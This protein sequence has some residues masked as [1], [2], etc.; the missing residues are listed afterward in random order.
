MSKSSP[1]ND[2]NIA[3]LE[4]LTEA[5]IDMTTKLDKISPNYGA[6]GQLEQTLRSLAKSVNDG[7]MTTKQ[8]LKEAASTQKNIRSVEYG[9]EDTARYNKTVSMFIKLLEEKIGDSKID[10]VLIDKITTAFENLDVSAILESEK[11]GQ[12]GGKGAPLKNVMDNEKLNKVNE[13]LAKRIGASLDETTDKL[14]NFF[15]EQEDRK[16][17]K[18]KRFADDLIEG[19]EKSKWVGG[20]M[21]DTF[22]LIGLLGA[23]WMRQF[24][25]L[26]RILG[27][28]FYV[29]MET[30]GPLLV[31]LLLQGM[32]KLLTGLPGLIGKF[33]WGA[34]AGVAAGTVGAMWAFGEARDSERKG[35][36]GN[37]EAFR[38]GGIGMA[39]GA[40]GIGLASL[41]SMGAGAA[42][43]T[44]LGSALA[45]IAGIL[46]PIGWT[47]LGIGAAV[48][49]IAWAW[50]HHSDTIKKWA[51][52]FVE[53]CDKVIDF[54][55]MFNPIF[56]AI[57]WIR[58]NWPWGGDSKGGHSGLGSIGGNNANKGTGIAD[59]I[60]DNKKG[61]YVTYGKMKVSKRDGSI[62]NLHELTQDEAS[63]AL[64]MYE[65]AD[66]TSFN[67]L[68]EWLEGDKASL[69]SHSTDAVKKVGGKKVAAL[70]HKGASKEIDD[71]RAILGMNIVQTSGKLTGSNIFHGVGGWKSHNNQYGLGFDLAGDSSWTAK[72]Y[73]RN[74][75]KVRSYY[76]KLG[77][78]VVLERP[79]QGK[80]TGFH[81]DIKPKK[82]WR[83]EGA[84][85]NFADYEQAQ[86]EAEAAKASDAVSR[87]RVAKEILKEVDPQ[88]L[89]DINSS[90]P[91]VDDKEKT[92]EAIA[93]KYE[94][95]LAPHNIYHDSNL[96]GNNYFVEDSSGNRTYLNLAP[97]NINFQLQ[98]LQQRGGN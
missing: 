72:D 56:K 49:G 57:Q 19:L 32:G 17:K 97:G 65:K 30:A 29:A 83:P 13:D 52:K 31:R 1:N 15:Q 89:K 75:E 63:K 96:K 79:G 25:Q 59:T 74:Y 45:G 73:E 27:A 39:A 7:T 91:Y 24:G 81:Y 18:Q 94:E 61:N 62:L 71:L 95:K 70:G 93:R 2:I 16:E 22:R 28:A 21:R 11:I 86:K 69:D 90:L 54:M 46:G 85:E 55:A 12:R 37:A 34:A 33:G 92:P 6:N 40:T 5:V 76:D 53:F 8:F 82:N 60:I 84:R 20:A 48:A 35:R 87:M 58:D 78:D 9:I 67:R 44:G 47:V 38:A 4:K 98:Q 77:F 64:Q 23:N 3:Y 80:S 42:G 50:K 41:A 14:I 26:G 51:G 36:R 10:D 66:P 88:A 68:Y 43:A